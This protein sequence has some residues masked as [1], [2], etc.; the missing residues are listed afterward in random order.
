LTEALEHDAGT[1]YCLFQFAR[2]ARC[3]GSGNSPELF[4]SIM[5]AAALAS[6]GKPTAVTNF[7]H[8][9]ADTTAARKATTDEERLKFWSAAQKKISFPRLAPTDSE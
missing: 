5:G 6:V 8:C 9:D 1:Q 4:T 2:Y 7:A 3:G